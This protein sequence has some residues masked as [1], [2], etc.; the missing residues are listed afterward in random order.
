M[1]SITGRTGETGEWA[2]AFLC[3]LC[4][5]ES[6]LPTWG[7]IAIAC[8]ASVELVQVESNCDSPDVKCTSHRPLD[9]LTDQKQQTHATRNLQFDY[10]NENC[11]T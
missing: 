9:G 1:S 3:N 4:I 10:R 2:V 7:R 5:L 11:Y 8:Q 6:Q